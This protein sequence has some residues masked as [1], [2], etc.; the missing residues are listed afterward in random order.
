M[1]RNIIVIIFLLLIL[2]SINLYTNE[3][4]KGKLDKFESEITKEKEEHEDN[5]EDNNEENDEDNG[6]FYFFFRTFLYNLFIGIPG[7]PYE[8]REFLWNYTF[9]KY[10][11]NHKNAGL[12]EFDTNKKMQLVVNTHYFYDTKDLTG[13]GLRANWLFVPYLGIEGNYLKL[14]EKLDNDDNDKDKLEVYDIYLNYQRFRFP[15]FNWWWGLGVKTVAGKD[16]NSGFSL[17]TGLEIYPIKP[18]SLYISANCGWLNGHPVSEIYLRLNLHINRFNFNAGY[19]KIQAESEKID[20]I[21]GGI[22]VH[23]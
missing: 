16:I 11:Y 21:T 12:Y 4:D 23:F 13:Y 20:G 7:D 9:S 19:Q 6:F 22:G 18:V 8:S 10:P 15:F 1:K 17:N 3:E 2:I 14:I 5:D